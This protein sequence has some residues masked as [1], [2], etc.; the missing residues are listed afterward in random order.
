MP[1]ATTITIW[2]GTDVEVEPIEELS[3]GGVR[4]DVDADDGP[5]W[6][7]DVTKAGNY[8]VVTSWDASGQLADVEVPEWIDD[9]IARLQ[10][11]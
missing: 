8:E 4:L 7:L 9:V 10:R 6:R 5:R 2:D 11:V 1:D 3:S